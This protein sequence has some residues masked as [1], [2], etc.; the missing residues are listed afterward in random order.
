M[1]EA[2]QVTREIQFEATAKTVDA[3]SGTLLKHRLS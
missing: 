2:K 3:G 1:F